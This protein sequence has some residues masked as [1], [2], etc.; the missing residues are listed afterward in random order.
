MSYTQIL[1]ASISVWINNCKNIQPPMYLQHIYIQMKI[2][3][4]SLICI[5]SSSLCTDRPSAFWLFLRETL[6]KTSASMRILP[7]PRTHILQIQHH[8]QLSPTTPKSFI[9]TT[10]HCIL[11]EY[12]PLQKESQLCHPERKPLV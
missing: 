4:G 6:R 3:K 7:Y 2:P 10:T 9:T 1:V 11:E 5:D 8:L 12:A